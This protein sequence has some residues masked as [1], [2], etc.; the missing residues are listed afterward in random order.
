[1]GC[2][3]SMSGEERPE[4]SLVWQVLERAATQ[5]M[6]A[7][8]RRCGSQVPQQAVEESRRGNS[9]CSDR[10]EQLDPARVCSSGGGELLE[11][12]GGG[13][14]RA[15]APQRQDHRDATQPRRNQTRRGRPVASSR[16]RQ[17][18][19]RK[20]KVEGGKALGEGQ[21]QGLRAR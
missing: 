1:M 13:S 14:A 16:E 4:A 2:V 7:V 8:A 15:D 17:D 10:L 9:K 20:C 11:E 3:R 6:G 5:A 12:S 21:G 18:S 19:G